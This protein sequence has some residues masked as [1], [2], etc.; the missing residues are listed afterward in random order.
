MARRVSPEKAGEILKQNANDAFVGLVFE[1]ASR[2]VQ[3]TPVK[4]GHARANWHIAQNTPN[5]S[6]TDSIDP[7]PRDV[8][9]NEVLTHMAHP[10]KLGEVTYLTNSLPY[11]QRLE[12]GWSKQSPGGMVKLAQAELQTLSR[13]VAAKIRRAF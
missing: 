4:T 12:H 3:K 11:I 10:T 8:P 13:E 9:G 1:S 2:I 5:R 7:T 6:V